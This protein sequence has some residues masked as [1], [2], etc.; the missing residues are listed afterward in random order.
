MHA[1]T[2]ARRTSFGDFSEGSGRRQCR[3]IA[4]STGERCRADA[5]ATTTACR[6]H[7]GLAAAVMMARKRD[8]S[9]R[10][11]ANN[12]AARE[13][14]AIEALAALADGTADDRGDGLAA[15]GRRSGCQR[16]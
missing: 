13:A 7:G 1:A 10:R 5:V 15:I 12:S 4:R 9:F 16:I 3:C 11:A 6:I 2:L 14:L 8:P